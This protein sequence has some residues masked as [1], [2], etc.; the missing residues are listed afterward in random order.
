MICGGSRSVIALWLFLQSLILYDI[1][2]LLSP[3]S[4]TYSE[5]SDR[6]TEGFTCFSLLSLSLLLSNELC[7]S[8]SLTFFTA[9]KSSSLSYFTTS[10]Y[11]KRNFRLHLCGMSPF[12][13]GWDLCFVLWEH[14]LNFDA[15]HCKFFKLTEYQLARPSDAN[16]KEMLFGSLARPGHPMKKFFWGKS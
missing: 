7:F 9:S 4:L 11:S 16:R 14:D 6:A 10:S 13:F 5:H 15:C 8:S 1:D 2:G 3:L 12:Q